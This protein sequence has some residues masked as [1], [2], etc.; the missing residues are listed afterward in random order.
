MNDAPIDENNYIELAN[1][2]DAYISEFEANG[3]D[4][5]LLDIDITP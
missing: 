3:T 4:N 5:I 1:R 2:I